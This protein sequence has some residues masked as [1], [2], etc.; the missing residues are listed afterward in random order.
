MRESDIQE[1]GLLSISK[2]AKLIGIGQDT[3]NNL[4]ESGRLGYIQFNVHKKIPYLEIRK[5]IENNIVYEDPEY[6]NSKKIDFTGLEDHT[7]DIKSVD[8]TKI[9]EQLMREN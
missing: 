7:D 1:I 9:F 8:T 4:I 6:K 2:A 5:F 3:L